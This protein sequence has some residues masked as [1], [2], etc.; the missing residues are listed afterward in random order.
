M[1]FSVIQDTRFKE[2]TLLWVYRQFILSPIKS[3]AIIEWPETTR[4]WYV[5]K[6]S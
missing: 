3:V 2:V 4:V 1:L 6:E 5:W